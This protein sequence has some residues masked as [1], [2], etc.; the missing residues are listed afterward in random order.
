MNLNDRLT[1]V[2]RDV[3]S[4]IKESTSPAVD[5]ILSLIDLTRLD[6]AASPMEINALAT[7][8]HEHH[9]AAICIFPDQ[10]KQVSSEN[11][12]KRAT[13]MNFPGGDEPTDR[14]IKNIN[15]ALQGSRLDE[16]DY[17]FPYRAYLSGNQNQALADYKAV[18]DHCKAHHLTFKVILETGALPSNEIIYELSTSILHLGCDFIKT[19]TGK[20]ENGATI[21]AV[22]SILSAILDTNIPAGIKVS[23]GVKTTEQAYTYIRLAEYMLNKKVNNQWFRLGA[24]GLLDELLSGQS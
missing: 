16:V 17:V 4:K 9:T 6:A 20:I 5:E 10:L 15:K 22:F 2:L 21:P 13:V 24:S 12:I 23:G 18:Y 1:N 19:S 3:H 8:A 14:V 7:K 11:P